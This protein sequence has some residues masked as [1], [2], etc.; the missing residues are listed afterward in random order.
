MSTIPLCVGFLRAWVLRGFILVQR[1]HCRPVTPS[2]GNQSQVLG[3]NQSATRRL[4]LRFASN[5]QQVRADTK[6]VRLRFQRSGHPEQ[7]AQ[8]AWV[9]NPGLDVRK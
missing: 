2:D 5:G 9:R 1:P 3:A 6:H 7:I 8:P 4:P